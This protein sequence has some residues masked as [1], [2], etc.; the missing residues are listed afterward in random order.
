MVKAKENSFLAVKYR[1]VILFVYDKLR[2]Y[3]WS[4]RSRVTKYI[5]IKSTYLPVQAFMKVDNDL[6]SI[7][8][9][10]SLTEYF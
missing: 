2:H 4:V 9:K 10:G 7:L 8:K 5:Y 1:H 3:D 6:V